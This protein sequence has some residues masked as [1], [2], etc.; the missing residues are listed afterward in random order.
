MRRTNPRLLQDRKNVRS[1]VKATLHAPSALAKAAPVEREARSATRGCGGSS[2]A[3]EPRGA[4][5]T[6]E[7]C[8]HQA[9]EE[10]AR[11]S[12]NWRQLKCKRK[13]RRAK[14]TTWRRKLLKRHRQRNS[15][16]IRLPPNSTA[17]SEAKTRQIHI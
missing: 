11:I 12:V 10:D 6:Q 13:L 2:A 1:M 5:E 15:C 14:C 7:R 8:G 17:F 3:G 16:I 9:C 4:K